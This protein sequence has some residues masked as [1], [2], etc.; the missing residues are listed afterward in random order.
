MR[1]SSVRSKWWGWGQEGESYH[2][3]NPERFWSYL[4][5]RLGD[6]DPAPRLESLTNV[7]LTPSRLSQGVVSELCRAVGQ[8]SVS[9]EVTDRVCFSLGKG[10]KDLVRIR[11]GEVP[12]PTDV[13]VR[14]QTEE[15]VLEVLRI[16]GRE[17]L[18]VVP[19]GGG[20]SVVGGVEP[21]GER[22]SITLDLA[23]LS[24][25]LG[26]DKHSATATVQAGI[27]GPDMERFLNPAGFTLGHF[28]QSFMYS[29]VG[30]WIAT[31]SAGQNSTRYGTIAER[32]QSLRLA[33]PEGI[34][35][36]PDVPAAAAGPDLVQL[37]A[38]SE[39]TLGVITQAT[40]RLAPLPQYQDYR[41]YLLPSF[42]EG[43][44]AA[45]ELMQ[46]GVA[47]AV[48]RLS[49][50]AETESTLA[51]RATPHGFAAAVEGLG[52]WY[53]ARRG[54][55]LESG[56]IMILGFEGREAEVRR[57]RSVAR[58]VLNR[59]RAASLGRGPGR[60]W[61]RGRYE[62]PYLRDLLLDHG[63]M[64]DTLETA[65]TWDRYLP[66]HAAVRDRLRE[67]LGDRSVVMAHLSHSYTDGASIYYTFLA[68]QETGAEVEQWDRVKAAATDVIVRNGGALSH[69]HG[70][71]VEHRRWMGDYLGEQGA[72]WLAAVK[73]ALDPGE[74]LN[75]GKLVPQPT[76]RTPSSQEG[77]NA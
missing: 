53:L 28:P 54:L 58:R 4:R 35:S 75:P 70:I 59:H 17:R 63:V 9:T 5:D 38:G 44:E 33:H 67:A 60:A 69:H 39:G 18:A 29:T 1:R 64:I 73:A 32:V 74:I 51:L 61:R 41:G 26:I 49:D 40:L 36:T 7:A 68:P 48:L 30:G 56:S 37:I 3:P 65:I 23:E 27:M 47:P 31:R 50:E 22:P 34:L 42:A 14:P 72:R 6:T 24:R 11:R 16:A 57:D 66:L 15:Q 52:R 8:E 55:G 12:Q 2:L 45:R 19:F 46:S 10:Y 21:A 13:V 71:G 20:T 76:A 62:A 77:G 25:P 43:V